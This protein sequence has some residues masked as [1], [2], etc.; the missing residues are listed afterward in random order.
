[1]SVDQLNQ[2]QSGSVRKS[3]EESGPR[4]HSLKTVGRK[5]LWVRA[6]R[7]PAFVLTRLV[8]S[9]LVDILGVAVRRALRP[10]SQSLRPLWRPGPGVMVVIIRLSPNNDTGRDRKKTGGRSSE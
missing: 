3:Q 7:P 4:S 2:N 9:L 5:P 8:S 6:P 10:L 1:M